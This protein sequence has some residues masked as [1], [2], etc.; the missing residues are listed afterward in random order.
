MRLRRNPR[1]SND[2]L[3]EI[4]KQ[5]ERTTRTAVVLGD[6]RIRAQFLYRRGS[7]AATSERVRKFWSDDLLEKPVDF[8][9]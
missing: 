7:R 8:Y 9:T 2:A 4:T 1:F 6:T 5:T 3:V